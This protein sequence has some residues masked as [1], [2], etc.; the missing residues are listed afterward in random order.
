MEP[1]P[2]NDFK[3]ASQAVIN[4]SKGERCDTYCGRPGP[5]GNPFK[6]DSGT[7]RRQS[8][9][10]HQRWLN[11]LINEGDVTPQELIALTVSTV[12]TPKPWGATA[13]PCC[14]TATP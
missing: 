12:G 10:N 2:W 9:D 6:I 1:Q 3:T 5:W 13:R 8:V 11:G 7:T 4:I 14:A